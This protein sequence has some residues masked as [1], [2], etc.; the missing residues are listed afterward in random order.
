MR[1]KL[2]CKRLLLL[3]LINLT[4]QRLLFPSKHTYPAFKPAQSIVHPLELREQLPILLLLLMIL[5]GE[6]PHLLKHVFL[7]AG[8]VLLAQVQTL[9]RLLQLVLHKLTLI[10]LPDANGL[11]CS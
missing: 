3:H 8:A 2:L 1:I 6:L 11:S 9:L 4:L 10:A 5:L 7:L